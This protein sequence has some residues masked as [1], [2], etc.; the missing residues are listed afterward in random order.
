MKSKLDKDMTLIKKS[1]IKLEDS[2][3]YMM[4]SCR[5]PMIKEKIL[6]KTNLST[7]FV[8]HKSFKKIVIN[9]IDNGLKNRLFLY[10]KTINFKNLKILL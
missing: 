1:N 7:W 2:T 4:N 9:C 5:K 8:K 3:N 6:L 10:M